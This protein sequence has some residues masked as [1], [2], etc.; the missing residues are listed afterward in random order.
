MF[1][2]E[3]GKCCC[4]D[5]EREEMMYSKRVALTFSIAAPT[6][7]IRPRVLMM[8]RTNLKLVADMAGTETKLRGFLRY[9]CAL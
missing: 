2:R 5:I 3:V 1:R 7:S 4:L 8:A 9:I 6:F